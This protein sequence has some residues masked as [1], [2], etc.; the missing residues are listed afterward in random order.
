MTGRPSHR[1]T[2]KNI[3][4]AVRLDIPL[5]VGIIASDGG[6]RVE[7]T[8]RDL[9]GLGVERIAVDRVRSFGR[10]AQGRAPDLADLCGR[11]GSGKA[12]V[13]P[14][15]EVS[16]CVLSGWMSVGNVKAAPLAAILGGSAMNLA[17]TAIRTSTPASAACGPDDDDDPDTEC[18]PGFP[19]SSCTPR[20]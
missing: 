10:G 1:R 15:G 14:T 9:E 13:G 12:A 4:T 19:G 18:T 20:T 2:R 16:P 17:A 7:E 5:R 11:C 6:Q 8:R 3:E